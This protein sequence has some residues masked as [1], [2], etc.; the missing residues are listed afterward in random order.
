M[1]WQSL[2]RTFTSRYARK[3]PLS[4]P[5]CGFLVETRPDSGRLQGRRPMWMLTWRLC[6][7]PALSGSIAQ[8]GGSPETRETGFRFTPASVGH[9]LQ[10][11]APGVF[12]LCDVKRA[13]GLASIWKPSAAWAPPPGSAHRA[14]RFTW[15]AVLYLNQ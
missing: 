1:R 15:W 11:T 2:Q 7:R 5:M 6:N 14:R 9:W 10:T 12:V 13:V 3:R 8:S 4:S